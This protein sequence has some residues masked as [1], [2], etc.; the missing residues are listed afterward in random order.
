MA[1]LFSPGAVLREAIF[2]LLST[3]HWI[4]RYESRQYGHV[5]VGQAPPGSAPRAGQLSAT[6]RS[7]LQRPGSHGGGPLN[8]AAA[9]LLQRPI[10]LICGTTASVQ[11]RL[12]TLAAEGAPPGRH[13]KVRRRDGDIFHGRREPWTKIPDDTLILCHHGWHYTATTRV[14]G[15]P[16]QTGDR[17]A[18]RATTP[19]EAGSPGIRGE[20]RSPAAQTALQEWSTDQTY[21]MA[22]FGNTCT[23]SAPARAV[24]CPILE[25]FGR[26]WNGGTQKGRPSVTPRWEHPL[27]GGWR[28]GRRPPLR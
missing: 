20:G 4:D 22:N 16:G 27:R 26:T 25:D 7:H 10:L 6:W 18:A 1:G 23:I 9:H 2:D 13:Y 24:L 17:T 14:G 5:L 19:S 11:M 12:N 8:A 3:Q 15:A 21:S 28:A